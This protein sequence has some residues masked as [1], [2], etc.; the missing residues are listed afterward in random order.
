MLSRTLFASICTKY[1]HI[2]LF[3][4]LVLEFALHVLYLFVRLQCSAALR[5]RPLSSCKSQVLPQALSRAVV[6]LRLFRVS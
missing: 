6:S 3:C 5:P 4:A 1:V 2:V